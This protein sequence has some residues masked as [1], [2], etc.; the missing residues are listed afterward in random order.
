MVIVEPWPRRSNKATCSNAQLVEEVIKL[1]AANPRGQNIDRIVVYPKKLPTDIRHNS[2]I[3]R[4]KLML[5]AN[6]R[7]LR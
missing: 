4:E 6:Q 1:L 2:K 5:W 3:F 7:F